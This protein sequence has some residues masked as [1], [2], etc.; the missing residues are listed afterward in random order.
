MKKKIPC[1]LLARK[2]SKGIKNKNRII[3]S[4]KSLIE[5]SIDYLKKSKLIDDIIVSTDDK[6]IAKI[7]M[8]K[9]CFTIFPRPKKL[10][11]DSASSEVALKHALEIYEKKNGK[12]EI[13]TF[14]QTTEFFKPQKI[15]DDCIKTLIKNKK[16][17]SCFAAY[18]QH[19]NFWTKR[20]SYL[21]RISSFTERY[22]P[23]QLKNPIYREDTGL[24]LATK[25]KF[26]RMG[27]RIGKK[28]KC[29]PYSNPLFSLDINT[30]ED[31]KLIKKILK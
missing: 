11:T 15:L 21:S 3:I 25:S 26:I 23:R 24:G 30:Y 4:G 13:T 1:I 8:K 29:V 17:D 16:I 2:N 18:K 6:K 10:S 14:I 28:V 5:H 7:S 31:L 20:N 27:E 9:K 19:K 22:K 12:T